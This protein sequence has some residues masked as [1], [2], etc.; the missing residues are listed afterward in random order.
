MLGM[1]G[2]AQDRDDLVW[3]RFLAWLAVAPPA[4]GPLEILQGYRASL[5]AKGLVPADAGEE[6]GSVMRLMRERNDAWPLM[7]NR[8]YASATPNFDTKPNAL[9]MTAIEGRAPGKALDIGMGQGRNAVA[10][11]LKGWNVTGFDVSAEGLAV[12]KAAAARAGVVVT[13]I[14]DSDERFDPGTN[15]WDL[16]AVIYGPGSIADSGYVARLHRSLTPG[17][18]VVVESFASD[19]SAAQRRPVDIDPADLRRAF[20]AFQILRFEDAPAVSDWD[21]QTTRLVR[22]VAQKRP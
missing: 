13:A 21:P 4:N 5:T 12:A 20:S 11:A 9:L 2:D 17:G 10:L 3:Q 16:I 8:I 18:V 6:M 15:Q 22:M 14:E 19:R 1:T 7:F